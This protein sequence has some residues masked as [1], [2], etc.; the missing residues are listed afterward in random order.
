LRGIESLI[1]DLLTERQA[2]YR[3][4]TLA[5]TNPIDATHLEVDG[6]QCVNFCSNNY[7]GLS[8][9][10]RILAA[11]ESA[12]RAAG[13][14]SGA[15]GLLRGHTTIHESAAR[16][17]AKWKG[18]QDAVLLPSGYQANLAAVQTLAAI[19]KSRGIQ[20]VRFLVDKLVHASILDA[21]SATGLPMRVFPHNNL[22]KLSRL[23]GNVN[24]DVVITE[25]IFSMDG[26]AAD[27]RGIAK[28][29]Q[30]HPFFLLLDEAHGSGVYGASGAGYANSLGLQDAVD[31][32]VVTL[33]KALGGIGGA[34]CS[35]KLFCRGVVNF[36]RAYIYSTSLPPAAAAAAE[37]AIGVLR[38]EPDRQKRLNELSRRARKELT[39]A[40]VK[41]LPGDSPII[42]CLTGSESAA[43][44]AAAKLF[45]DGLIVAPVR[46]PTVAPGASR[47]RISLCSQ[48]T[49]EEVTALLTAI[50]KLCLPLSGARSG[51]D[52]PAPSSAPPNPA[53]AERRSRN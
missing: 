12:M 37:A 41:I 42:C 44:K 33:S 17:I 15:A 25:S 43:L 34:I 26:D 1:H 7:L 49:D 29:K 9:H 50:K 31:A 14:G 30:K 13:F 19:S 27:L 21:V 23:L 18:T 11:A 24:L 40:G 20:P 22:N 36:G 45:S 46:P 8:R 4:R 35:T 6:K 16:A 53:A 39:A 38:D 3:L 10:P 2:S 51:P 48:H 52:R 47:L 28:L 5:A 32:S